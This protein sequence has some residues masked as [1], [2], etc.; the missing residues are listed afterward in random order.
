MNRDRI[1]T[2]INVLDRK[3]P[4]WE[5]RLNPPHTNLTPIINLAAWLFH[6]CEKPGTEEWHK[7]RPQWEAGADAYEVAQMLDIS[8]EEGLNLCMSKSAAWHTVETRYGSDFVFDKQNPDGDARKAE[9]D[10]DRWKPLYSHMYH[11][12]EAASHDQV[13]KVLREFL[14]SG[15]IDWWSSMDFGKDAS[16]NEKV[17]K[18]QNAS[19]EDYCKNRD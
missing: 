2:M 4:Q 7:K 1:Q 8:E 10:L 5:S 16:I 11:E 17:T 12:I 9:F 15:N 6:D 13:K 18:A 14:M 3:D 19:F